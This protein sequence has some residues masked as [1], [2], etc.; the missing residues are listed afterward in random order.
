M[1]SSQNMYFKPLKQ[2]NK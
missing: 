2:F 1:L